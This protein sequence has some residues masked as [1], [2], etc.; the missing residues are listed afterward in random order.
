MIKSKRKKLKSQFISYLISDT[1]TKL[2]TI[3]KEDYAIHYALQKLNNYLRSGTFTI[4]TD[5]KPLK[6]L[7]YSSIQNKKI[8]IWASY[9]C[10]IQYLK[11]KDNI[12]VDL[13]TR[14]ADQSKN[15]YDPPVDIGNR[16]YDD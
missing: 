2:P 15:N 4:Y 11:G 9:D 8:Q 10:K 6:Y 14:A 16:I 5:H 7:F 12:Y 1:Q 3:E 13:L